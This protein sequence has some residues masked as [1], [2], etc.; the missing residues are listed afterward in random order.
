VGP[1]VL[2]ERLVPE[3]DWYL[4]RDGRLRIDIHDTSHDSFKVDVVDLFK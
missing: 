1:P 4:A 2:T 3:G